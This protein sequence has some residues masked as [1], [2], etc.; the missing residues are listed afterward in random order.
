MVKNK[1][2]LR[3]IIHQYVKALNEVVPIDK[4]IL[5]GSWV[6]GKPHEYSDID[7]AIFSSNFGKNKLKEMQ[8]LSKIAFQVDASIEAIPYS[9]EKIVTEDTTSFVYEIIN[10][11][12]T[13]YDKTS[14]RR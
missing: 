6:N 4:V 14:R 1:A 10:T 5:Y 8:L 13:V 7:L 2:A 3:R 9:T 12:V 11:G